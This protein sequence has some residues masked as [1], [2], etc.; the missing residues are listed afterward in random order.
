M[1]Y[2]VGDYAKILN[3]CTC[4]C[5]IGVQESF[6]TYDVSVFYTFSEIACASCLDAVQSLQRWKVERRLSHASVVET[7]SIRSLLTVEDRRQ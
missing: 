1:A 7:V 6:P 4:E 3:V 2:A 5:T